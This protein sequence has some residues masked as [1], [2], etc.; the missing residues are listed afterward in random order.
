M[1]S[2]GLWN[3]KSLLVIQVESWMCVKRNIFKYTCKR[4]VNIEPSIHLNHS[5]SKCA[6]NDCLL[7]PGSRAVLR[8]DFSGDLDGSGRSLI[9]FLLRNNLV[10]SRQLTRCTLHLHEPLRLKR[11]EPFWLF[12]ILMVCEKKM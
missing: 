11:L 6:Q 4:K 2:K 9:L 3:I 1:P 8:R 5:L 10:P 12:G 7:F